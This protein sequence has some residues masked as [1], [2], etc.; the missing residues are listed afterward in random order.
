LISEPLGLS[1]D[2]IDQ[3][4]TINL[5]FQ[6]QGIPFNLEAA[7]AADFDAEVHEALSDGVPV[8]RV[9]RRHWPLDVAT[10]EPSPLHSQRK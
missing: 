2:C 8:C 10:P 5:D 6:S 4:L 9:S 7:I 1:S 3:N